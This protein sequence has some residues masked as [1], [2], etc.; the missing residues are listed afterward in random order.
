[1]KIARHPN[2]KLAAAKGSAQLRHG[3]CHQVE[4]EIREP[5]EVRMRAV[6]VGEDSESYPDILVLGD[7]GDTSGWC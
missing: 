7:E 1:M 2:R 6:A 3:L 5:D 4:R